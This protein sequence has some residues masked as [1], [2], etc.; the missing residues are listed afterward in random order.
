MAAVLGATLINQRSSTTY[1]QMLGLPALAPI[2]A[3]EL[4]RALIE[5]RGNKVVKI[6]LAS[7]S[8]FQIS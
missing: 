3:R 2:L 8:C 4:V 5:Y 1:V 7:C 6:L